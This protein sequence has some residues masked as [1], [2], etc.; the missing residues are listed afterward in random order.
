MGFFLA[1]GNE[2]SNALQWYRCKTWPFTVN[3][4]DSCSN[5]MGSLTE[6]G[7]VMFANGMIGRGDRLSLFLTIN[8]IQVPY[9][10][11]ALVGRKFVINFLYRECVTV[12]GEWMILYVCLMDFC[13]NFFTSCLRMSSAQVLFANCQNECFHARCCCVIGIAC[14]FAAMQLLQN[15][16]EGLGKQGLQNIRPRIKISD[17]LR[18]KS[19]PIFWLHKENWCGMDKLVMLGIQKLVFGV[20]HIFSS[21]SHLY[22]HM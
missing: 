11:S 8:N 1:C 9:L 7:N 6:N 5:S 19:C 20:F 12:N 22:V 4:C 3:V 2:L 21:T 17:H 18:N 10:A 15:Y 16:F 13:R 14:P